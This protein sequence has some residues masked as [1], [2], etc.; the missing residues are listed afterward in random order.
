M[1]IIQVVLL[2]PLDYKFGLVV[3]SKSQTVS[4]QTQQPKLWRFPNCPVT[5]DFG[6]Y[7]L[8]GPKYGDQLPQELLDAIHSILMDEIAKKAKFAASCRTPDFGMHPYDTI[9][10]N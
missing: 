2:D 4:A 3:D 10:L 5:S 7:L 9:I 1:N 6:Q 8:S